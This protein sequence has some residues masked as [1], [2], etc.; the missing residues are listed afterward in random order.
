MAEP[1]SLADDGSRG[2]DDADGRPRRRAH[3]VPSGKAMWG[4]ALMVVA[5]CAEADIRAIL[6]V[7]PSM[8][9]LCAAYA[10]PG[11]SETC[12]ASP[13][14]PS[15]SHPPATCI[16]QDRSWST[17]SC[18]SPEDVIPPRIFIPLRFLPMNLPL[19]A[20]RLPRA[21]RGEKRGAIHCPRQARTPYVTSEQ[22]CTLDAHRAA[23]KL[24]G[25]L[26]R[27]TSGSTTAVG[28]SSQRRVG[29][30]LGRKLYKLFSPLAHA[31]DTL[32]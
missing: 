1:D 24:V 30:A 14:L 3:V 8:A 20:T 12:A 27:D 17:S 23:I 16:Y 21:C 10:Q 18:S 28:A 11:L 2:D 13:P 32:Q 31:R 9:H 29:P 5:G 6:A 7:Y 22:G 15:S 4:R 19:L 25:D 26:L